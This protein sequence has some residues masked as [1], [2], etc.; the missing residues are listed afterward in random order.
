LKRQRQDL[1]QERKD[2]KPR[3]RLQDE[4]TFGKL[5]GKESEMELDESKKRQNEDKT[6]ISQR[7]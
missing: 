6:P 4:R 5:R 1:N 2:L 3:R 7:R